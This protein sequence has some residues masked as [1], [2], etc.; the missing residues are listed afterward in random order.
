MCGLGSCTENWTLGAYF[1]HFVEP[2]ICIFSSGLGLEIIGIIIHQSGII[3]PG[4]FLS[5]SFLVFFYYFEGNFRNH[6][7]S[8]GHH[9]DIMPLGA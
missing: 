9:A 8:T 4:N 6:D 7:L 5:F 3:H 1:F 2:G